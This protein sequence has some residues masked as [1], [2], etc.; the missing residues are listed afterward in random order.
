MK[1][2][3]T[4]ELES[5]YPSLESE[6]WRADRDACA[7]ALE[8][9]RERAAAMPAPGGDPAAW[10]ALL[11]DA[12]AASARLGHLGTYVNC[13]ASADARDATARRESATVDRMR[14][15]AVQI[16]AALAAGL[17]AA[18]ADTYGALRADP[19]L[20]GLGHRLDKLRDKARLSM[21]P[22]LEMLAADLGVNGMDAWGRLYAQVTGEMDFELAPGRRVP[23]A[24]RRSLLEDRD[25][26]VRRAALV[27]GNEELA[28]R[29]SVFAAALNA[30]AGTRLTL[31]RRRGVAHFLDA[32][33]RDADITRRTLDTMLDTVAEHRELAR[34]YLRAKARLL[35]KAR[36]G[37]QDLSAPLATGDAPAIDWSTAER[38]LVDAFARFD[39]AMAAFARDAFAR[40]WI[41]AEP[42]AGK[43]PGGYCASSAITRESRIFMTFNDTLGDTQTLAHELGHAWHNH[44]MRDLRPWAR[45][46]PMTLAETAS[47]FAET[48]VG[49]ALLA[50]PGTDEALRLQVLDLRMGRAETFLLDIP[51]RFE[52]ERA[53]Y[54]ERADGELSPE[55]L[56]ALMAETQR[57]VYGDTLADD[58]LDPWFWASKLHYYITGV[59]FYNFPYTFGYLFSL[60]V[61]ARARAAGEAFRAQ[62]V[63]LLRATGQGTAEK[64]ARD[65][66]GVDLESPDFWRE[67]LSMVADDLERFEREVAS[68]F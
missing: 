39:P 43:R 61:Y 30:I 8:A 58:E 6:A 34:R 56:C 64:V 46:Y 27:N 10:V 12:E 50:D 59:S 62:W 55:R 29:A 25:P 51:M 15:V 49:D 33:V 20:A 42:R 54:E 19:A 40:R 63:A 5:W 41:E 31:Y 52:F 4:W 65:A 66:L 14:A 23:F 44:A 7:A 13:L 36:L 28:K 21:A 22:E 37:F 32:A 18:T 47:T 17:G 45:R 35:G 26:A 57:R 48:I 24:W 68:S 9:I 1:Q 11:N 60:G 38:L 16:E 53:F 3:P 2:A 67:T